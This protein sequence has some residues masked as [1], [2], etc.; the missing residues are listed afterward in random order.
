MSDN[1][2]DG[3]AKI[4]EET[5]K[6]EEAQNAL[7]DKIM[8]ELDAVN[9][10][11]YLNYEGGGRVQVVHYSIE[12]LNL[13]EDP[14]LREMGTLKYHRAT[15]KRNIIESFIIPAMHACIRA[16]IVQPVEK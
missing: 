12:V 13:Q 3:I 5:R 9:P 16:G 8:I 15:L 11:W 14:D 10:L 1:W 4:G 7:L 2:L 6:R